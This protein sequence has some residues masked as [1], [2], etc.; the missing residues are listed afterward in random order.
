[1]AVPST[2][3]DHVVRRAWNP[4]RGPSSV[5]VRWAEPESRYAP[6][7]FQHKAKPPARGTADE[8]LLIL[9]G[10]PRG[11]LRHG[12]APGDFTQPSRG[13]APRPAGTRPAGRGDVERPLSHPRETE[14]GASHAGSARA[15][16]T[17]PLEAWGVFPRD[18]SHAGRLTAALA[19]PAGRVS[20]SQTMLTTRREWP[21]SHLAMGGAPARAIQELAGCADL[22][23]TQRYMHLSPAALEGAIRLRR[24][25]LWRHSGDGIDPSS[26]T[27]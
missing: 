7:P 1:M 19:A 8:R 21:C 15:E 6:R 5:P 2:K 4:Y 17:R 11:W 23:T 26:V 12:N 18:A 24:S 3:F 25:P 14:H 16:S 22:R 20:S 13:A 27:S 9:D 10:P